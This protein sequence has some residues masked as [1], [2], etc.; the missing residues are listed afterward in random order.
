[1][2]DEASSPSPPEALPN[3]ESNHQTLKNPYSTR[4]YTNRERPPHRYVDRTR[5]GE[6]G[7]QCAEHGGAEMPYNTHMHVWAQSC[8]LAATYAAGKELKVPCS[9]LREDCVT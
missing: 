6:S 1:M 8:Q 3:G 2:N 7:A 5:E 4:P 9:V